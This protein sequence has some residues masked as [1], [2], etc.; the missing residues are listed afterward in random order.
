[1]VNKNHS[2]D[3]VRGIE[4]LAE[5]VQ[6]LNDVVQ[7]WAEY[8]RVSEEEK[9]KRCEIEAWEKVTLAEIQAKRDFLIGYLEHSFDERA[10][11]FRSLFQIVDQAISA[12]DN[13]QLGLAL[14][15]VVALAESSPF[16]NLADLSTVKASLDDPNHVWEF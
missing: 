12:G 2:M 3:F 1:M 10:E 13:Q 6:C 9:T 15:S 16:K 8:L 4:A 5:P 11:N 14:H 7:A